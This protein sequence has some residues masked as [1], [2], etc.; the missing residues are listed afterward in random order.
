MSFKK[1]LVSLLGA[2]IITFSGCSLNSNSYSK[3]WNNINS[4]IPNSLLKIQEYL[5][6]EMCYK[7]EKGDRWFSA[8]KT[9]ELGFG[10]CEDIAILGSY[11]AESL[12]YSPKV[13]FIIDGL[14]GGHAITLLEKRNSKNPSKIKY[15]AIDKIDLFHPVYD[16]ID[17]LIYDINKIQNKNYSYY[18]T[19]NLNSFN[20]NW[21]TSNKDL[22][23]S[24]KIQKF[25]L[26]KVKSNQKDNQ[27]EANTK[28][29]F[30]GWKISKNLIFLK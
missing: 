9:I 5:S 29:D 10:D 18:I 20:K 21:R 19:I 13:L 26:T 22:I 12:E 14:K 1:T 8:K 27:E 24:E 3:K 11:F 25:H 30:K 6:K 23:T 17:N 28:K 2:G 16:S 15:G 4:N 7:P